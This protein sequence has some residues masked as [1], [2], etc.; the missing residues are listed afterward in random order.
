[1]KL[2]PAELGIIRRALDACTGSSSF[3]E[4]S[5]LMIPSPLVC[6][7]LSAFAVLLPTVLV[8]QQGVPALS[9]RVLAGHNALVINDLKVVEDDLCRLA[10]DVADQDIRLVLKQFWDFEKTGIDPSA[11]A[12]AYEN[13]GFFNLAFEMRIKDLAMADA[14]FVDEADSELSIGWRRLSNAAPL[15]SV[16]VGRSSIGQRVGERLLLT[17]TSR[18]GREK[19]LGWLRS[20]ESKLA[21]TM[22]PL[23]HEIINQSGITLIGSKKY[24]NLSDVCDVADV[25]DENN[26]RL[27][28]EEEREWVSDLAKRGDDA[29]YA[30]F[31]LKYHDRVLEG[32][33]HTKLAAGAN[34]DELFELKYSD[35]PWDAGLGFESDQL[36][37]VISVRMD[38]FKSAVATRAVP[39]ML[40]DDIYHVGATKFLKGSMLRVLME[41]VGD[42]WNDLTAARIGIYENDPEQNLGQVSIVGVVDAKD[43]T[44]VIAELQQMSTL[45]SPADQD[46]ELTAERR[47]VIEKLIKDLA[48]DSRTVAS[49]AATRL[50]LGGRL[51]LELLKPLEDAA[52]KATRERAKRVVAVIER[53]FEARRQ[54]PGVLDPNF[55]TTLNPKLELEVAGKTEDG[56]NAFAIKISADS[57]KSEAEVQEASALMQALFGE[58]W[59]RISVVQ[60]ED[61]FV[62]MIGS[63]KERL[64]RICRKVQQN[65]DDLVEHLAGVGD[66]AQAGQFQVAFDPIRVDRIFGIRQRGGM[67][68][69]LQNEK[70]EV[71]GTLCWIG[72]YLDKESVGFQGLFPVEQFGFFFF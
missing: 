70:K 71:E 52:E 38:A 39:N 18:K 9:Q 36:A 57:S 41:L 48:S 17:Q 43:P 37:G 59:D 64:K 66:G 61:H 8:A 25:V 16:W 60:V 34:L 63:D 29:E 26:F 44:Q 35:Q 21:P 51:V 45:L 56:L 7:L 11:G 62:F 30:L 20:A 12:I 58:Q 55:W 5:A 3:F 54:K 33:C 31:G 22:D 69:G 42:S 24:V 23:S 46:A 50:K 6:P 53:K 1:M 10:K 13:N 2:W 47:R 14:N 27:L 4:K 68:Y 28:N 67:L 65:K 19:D 40:L 72:A 49:R 15:K 32:R